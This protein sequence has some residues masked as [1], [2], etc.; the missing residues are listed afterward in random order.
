MSEEEFIRFFMAQDLLSITHPPSLY[1]FVLMFEFLDEERT[2]MIS[3]KN[4][5]NFLES[6]ERLKRANFDAKVYEQ[7]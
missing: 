3:A 1:D 7:D 4:F 5:R 2:G 6:A